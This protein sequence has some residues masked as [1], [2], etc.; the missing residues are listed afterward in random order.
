MVFLPWVPEPKNDKK[1]KI[2]KETSNVSSFSLFLLPISFHLKIE[3]LVPRV[4]YFIQVTEFFTVARELYFASFTRC[5]T[6]VK[7]K[8]PMSCSRGKCFQSMLQ[9]RSRQVSSEIQITG[10][11][12]NVH[13]S[14]KFCFKDFDHFL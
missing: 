6:S 9:T 13:C 2:R 10:A 5:K 11:D 7:N 12:A 4:W 1:K 3:A 14:K 8:T